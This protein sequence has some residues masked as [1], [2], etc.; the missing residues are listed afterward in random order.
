MNNFEFW[1]PTKIVF[2]K[3]QIAQ[4]KALVPVGARVLMTYGLGSIKKNG[5]YDQVMAA[6]SGHHVVEFGGI[7]PNPDYDHMM[8]AVPLIKEHQLDFI[9]S[10][11]GGSVVDGSKFLA[12]AACASLDPWALVT[13]G[14]DLIDEALPH[15]AVLTLP[16]TGTEMNRWSVLSRRSMDEKRDFGHP[17]LFLQF[18]VLDP[19]TTL[20]L[21]QKQIANGIVDAFVHVIEQYVT[22]PIDAPLQDRQAEA[23][24]LTLIEQGRRILKDPQSYEARANFMWAATAAL[25]GLI[26]AGTTSDWTTHKIGHELTALYGLDHAETLAVV[27]PAVFKVLREQKYDKLMQYGRHVWGLNHLTGDALVDAAIQATEDFFVEVGVKVR[28]S[29]YGIASDNLARIADKIEANGALPLS[30]RKNVGKAEIVK[31]LE[32][33]Y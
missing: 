27:L 5:V 33:C 11:G 26:E 9:L 2:G 19:A 15:G 3:G 21:P 18:A 25:N 1:A 13:S 29:D 31:I 30:E 14:G 17:S 24:L 28:L 12:A 20:T 22:Y 32:A 7:T 4:L 6:L 16:A 8:K 10:V 23:V